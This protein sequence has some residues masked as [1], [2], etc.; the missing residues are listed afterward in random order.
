MTAA[1]LHPLLTRLARR[2]VPLGFAAAVVAF[3]FATPTPESLL[4]GL[5]IALPGE[6]LRVWAAGHIEKGREI[7]TSGPYR[8]TRHPL[9]LGS[10]ILGAGFAVA[11][12]SLSVTLVV[13]AYLG[14]TLLAAVRTEEAVLDARFDGAYLR[15]REGRHERA[16][17]PFRWERV[18]ANREYRAIVGFLLAGL[19]LSARA[20]G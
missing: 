8:L 10:S 11:A 2:R 4:W 15:Y 9:Y 5:A 1:G 6:A 17:R 12:N 19:L 14:V 20:W 3:A 7:T 16:V 13:A 18:M